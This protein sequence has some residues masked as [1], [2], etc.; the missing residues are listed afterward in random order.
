[1]RMDRQLF[2][3]VG[4]WVRAHE[5]EIVRDVMRLVAI[6]SVS[7]YDEAGTP[8]GAGC[9]RA[10]EEMLA[11]GRAQGFATR[12]FEDHCG[13]LWLEEKDE[14]IGLW[15]HLDVVPEGDGWTYAPFEPFYR[16]GYVVGR[17]A[18]DNK[19]STVGMLYVMRCLK[20][21]G[22][23]LKHGLKL[24]VGCDEEHGMR[25][26]QYYAA[27]YRCPELSMIADCG[28]PVCYGE[29]GIIEADI[30]CK[31][32]LSGDVLSLEGGVASNVVP[33]RASMRL[34]ATPR[35]RAALEAA[36]VP[37]GI[38]VTWTDDTAG[39]EAEGV[40]RHTAF[41]E[42]GVNAVHRLLCFAIDQDILSQAD[43]AT[44]ELLR[45]V[46]T[47]YWGSALGIRRHDDLSGDLTCVG[48]MLRLEDAHA[49]LHV[50][51]RYCVME[52]APALL[53]QMEEAAARRGCYIRLVRESGPNY[54]PKE[55]P[56]VHALM[57]A[58]RETTGSDAEPYVMGGGTYARKLP[59]ALGFG[60][61]GLR[62]AHCPFLAES[63][64]GAHGPDEALDVENLLQAMA[65]FAMGLI[66][67]DGAL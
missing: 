5:D 28:F 20:E 60:L 23:Q 66:E 29:K 15:G 16:D 40:S 51:I 17:G 49:A 22:V 54:F 53:K 33:S 43:A 56:A 65:V 24:F 42:G 34:R 2:E 61:G 10:L 35:V 57:R 52:K 27:H 11:I 13:A 18:D 41:P 37:E 21:L 39:I 9:K 32:A 7:T 47:D 12:N 4:A 62:R 63:H 59:N 58:Y 3:R 48:S 55:H 67:A 46:N 38:A 44:L 36:A 25:D 8:Y 31:G 14:T 45:Q 19:G 6:R 30:V 1:M 50:N 64:G 26:V